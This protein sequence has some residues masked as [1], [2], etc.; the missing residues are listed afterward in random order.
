LL[1]CPTAQ[2]QIA[3]LKT[4]VCSNSRSWKK[5]L[6]IFEGRFIFTPVSLRADGLPQPG[7]DGIAGLTNHKGTVPEAIS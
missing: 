1:L 2:L 3:S 7:N 5:V 6:A 4:P